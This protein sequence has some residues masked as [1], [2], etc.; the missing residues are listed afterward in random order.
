[1]VF[2][3]LKDSIFIQKKKKNQINKSLNNK[4]WNGHTFDKCVFEKKMRGWIYDDMLS[5]T[6]R[7]RE[8]ER[9]RKRESSLTST[10]PG[11]KSLDFFFSWHPSSLIH[12]ILKKNWHLIY[13]DFEH[14]HSKQ[15]KRLDQLN[16]ATLSLFALLL[17]DTFFNLYIYI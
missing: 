7:Q 16:F 8:R 4:I 13:K 9:M 11:K 6:Q 1:M 3:E 17:H 12:D 2:L 14:E 10:W 15:T 5:R